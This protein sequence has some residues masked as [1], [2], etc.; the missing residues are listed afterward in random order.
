VTPAAW[1]VPINPYRWFSRSAVP[2][3]LADMTESISQ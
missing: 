1:G 3:R 2:K